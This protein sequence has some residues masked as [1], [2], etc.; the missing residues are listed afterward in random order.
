MK[1][2]AAP[3]EPEL[4]RPLIV[5]RIASGGVHEHIVARPAEREALAARFGLAALPSLEAWLDAALAPNG[6]VRLTGR[7]EAEVVQTCVVTLEP[8]PS[9]LECPL[10]ALFAPPGLMGQADPETACDPEAEDPPEAIVNGRID[11]GEVVAQ[12]LALALD[13]YP[14]KPGATFREPLAG[15]GGREE[16]FPNPFVR[17]RE[18]SKTAKNQDAEG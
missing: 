7:L 5:D 9:R 10:G 6:M 2:R 11:L 8:L 16:G 4:S 1:T 12:N 13:P 14:R 18:A 17:L 3:P 15:S